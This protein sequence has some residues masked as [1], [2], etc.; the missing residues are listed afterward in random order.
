MALKKT[1]IKENG[2]VLTYHKINEIHLNKLNLATVSQ[3][4]TVSQNATYSVECVVHSY[5]DE[6]R[7]RENLNNVVD[8]AYCSFMF[9]ED[10]LS[11]LYSNLYS[12]LKTMDKYS[13]AE[14]V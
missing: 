13:G 2:I 11:N 5:V 6:T 14:D 1:I 3:N 10:E 4:V 7:R 12:K 9:F 8:T